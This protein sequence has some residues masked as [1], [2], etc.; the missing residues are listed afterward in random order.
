MFVSAVLWS[1]AGS[2]SC[3]D[4]PGVVVIGHRGA[5]LEEL[6]NSIASFSR[7]RDLGAD[8]VELDVQLTADGRLIVMHDPSLDRTTTCTGAVRSRKL[9]EL[10]T[11]TLR[12]GE[13][14]RALEQVLEIVVPWF[15]LVF[16]EIKVDEP[17]DQDQKADEAARVALSGRF[18]DK[19]VFTSYDETVNRRLAKRRAEGIHAATDDFTNASIARAAR[20]DLDWVLIRLDGLDGR[21]GTIVNGLGKRLCVYG[22]NTPAHFV[23]AQNAGVDVMMTESIRAVLSLANRR[24]P[25]IDGGGADRPGLSGRQ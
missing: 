22:I 19:V 25:P 4:K 10:R 14:I 13:P 11:C 17:M 2:T 3:D 21:E 23:K 7:A 5:P 16:V 18:A 9:A 8:G 20:Y 15:T 24:P 1:A 6:E 12:N